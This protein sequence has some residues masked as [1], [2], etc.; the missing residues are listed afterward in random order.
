MT[1]DA[2]AEP[3]AGTMDLDEFMTFFETR[4]KGERWDLIEGF[5]VMMAPATFAHRRIAFNLSDVLNRAFAS[6]HLDL[7]AYSGVCVRAPGVRNFQPQPDVAVVPGVAGYDLYLER[8]QLVA[9]V[10]SALNTRQ[11]IDVKL[12][13]Y[14]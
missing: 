13:R 7:F 10:L 2:P 6:G 1:V 9:E 3:L 5:A 11:E 8:F 14:R 12:H 4:P